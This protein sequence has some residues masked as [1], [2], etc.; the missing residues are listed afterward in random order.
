[1]KVHPCNPA[2]DALRLEVCPDCGYSLQGLPPQKTCPECGARYGRSAV[3][4]Y[5]WARGDQARAWNRTPLP[6]AALVIGF[7]GGVL[8]LPLAEWLLSPRPPTI[9]PYFLVVP[10][11]MMAP[12]ALKLAHR[13]VSRVPGPVQVRLNARGCLQVG[14]DHVG[15]PSIFSRM[16]DWYL[17]L[18]PTLMVVWAIV[19]YASGRASLLFVFFFGGL[20][21]LILAMQV[22]DWLDFKWLHFK[23]WLEDRR[24]DKFHPPR[25]GDEPDDAN[26]PAD[27]PPSQSADDSNPPP[28]MFF[29]LTPTR[30][31]DV[32][33]IVIEP[34]GRRRARV[35][36]WEKPPARRDHT[37]VDAIVR[38]TPAQAAALRERVAAWKSRGKRKRER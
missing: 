24:I 5:G 17:R 34:T 11:I 10:G 29:A 27:A 30:W 13:W 19:G 23:W 18:M 7:G 37:A 12:Q 3:V 6:T 4:L 35:T 31:S 16:S 38:C 15:P 25:R 22:K 20:G 32:G 33:D 2:E 36:F 26:D 21:S 9:D 28:P 1:M 14:V 8:G